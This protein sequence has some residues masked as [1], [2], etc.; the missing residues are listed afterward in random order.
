[1]KWIY[2]KF[3]FFTPHSIIKICLAIALI[4][5]A[6][7]ALTSEFNRHPDEIHHFEAAKYYVNHFLPPVIGD[8]AVRDSYSVYGVSYL[9]YHWLEYLLACLLYTSPSPR[10]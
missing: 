6:A 1:M 8:A 2:P 7:M 3:N 9:N 4:L 10:D 5:S